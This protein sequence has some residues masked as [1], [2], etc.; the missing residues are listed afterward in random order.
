M[1]SN[2]GWLALEKKLAAFVDDNPGESSYS[3]APGK[4]EGGITSV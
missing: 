1:P 3:D 4:S 2:D